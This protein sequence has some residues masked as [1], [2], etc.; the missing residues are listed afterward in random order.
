MN[1]AKK[2]MNQQNKTDNDA[3]KAGV[4]ASGSRD[5]GD[6]GGGPDRKPIILDA[7]C[8]IVVLAICIVVGIQQLKP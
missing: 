6:A 8:V 7:I 1:S 5:L 4:P 3:A 2:L